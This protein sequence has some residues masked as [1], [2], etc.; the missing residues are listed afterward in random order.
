M[1][2]MLSKC[3]INIRT[4]LN[5]VFAGHLRRDNRTFEEGKL[6]AC[7]WQGDVIIAQIPLLI[8]R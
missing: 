8:I 7:T 6:F 4:I 2:S 1:K 5:I 3:T